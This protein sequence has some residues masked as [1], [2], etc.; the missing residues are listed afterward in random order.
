MLEST[1]YYLPGHGGQLLTGLGQGIIERG[2][3]VVGRETRGEF[4]S[5]PFQAQID[6]VANDL[7]EHFWR[8]SAC[9]I[10]NSF[11]AYLF[12]HAQAQLPPFVG[13][14]LL[15]SPIVGDFQDENTSLGFIPPRADK[16]RQLAQ[17]GEMPV[18]RICEVHVGSEDWQSNP[19]NVGALGKLLGVPVNIV[20]GG[21][22]MLGKNYVGSVLDR[23][24]PQ[25]EEKQNI[26]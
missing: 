13:R 2:F 14:V 3:D 12:L 24:L 6:Q 17:A 19:V 25:H 7:T 23:W 26:A 16:I 5:L 18:P 20:D 1:I 11:G 22:H 4:K 8:E 15:L 10:A 21:G 9:V